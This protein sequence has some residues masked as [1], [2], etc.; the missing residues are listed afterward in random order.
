MK[1]RLNPRHAI[2]GAAIVVFI[3]AFVLAGLNYRFGWLSLPKWLVWAGAILFL[4]AYLMW[5]EVLREN[6]FLSRTIEVH[7]YKPHIGAVV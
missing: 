1:K 4:L 3:A 6:A 7:G 2:L 5:G